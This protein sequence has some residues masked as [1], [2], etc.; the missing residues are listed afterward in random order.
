VRFSNE[1]KDSLF[2]D[3][4][5]SLIFQAVDKYFS[6]QNMSSINISACATDD[7]PSVIGYVYV[8]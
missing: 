5:G 8:T 3:T 4:K 2:T 1:N 6:A 7:A